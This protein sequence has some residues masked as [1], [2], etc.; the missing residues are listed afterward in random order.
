MAGN[1][2]SR[3]FHSKRERFL[4]NAVHERT[5]E[6]T[7]AGGD[8]ASQRYYFTLHV[9]AAVAFNHAPPSFH[10]PKEAIVIA[11][12]FFPFV[13]LAGVCDLCDARCGT[14]TVGAADRVEELAYVVL[15]VQDHG[16]DFVAAESQ[17]CTKVIGVV[18]LQ[19]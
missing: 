17:E 7:Q 2:T 15:G 13:G 4:W 10:P 1:R 6:P 11:W 19:F 12:H 16:D 3:G 9:D 5:D 18:L 8:I 14:T